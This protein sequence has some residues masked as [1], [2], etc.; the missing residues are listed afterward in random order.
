MLETRSV[1]IIGPPCAGKTTLAKL[2]V[3]RL[4]ENSQPCILLDGDEVRDVF[5]NQLGYDP[6][7]RRK[8]T[9]R[10]KKLARLV[11]SGEILPVIA[12]IHPFEDDRAK[13]REQ[14]PGY[15][16]VVLA[17]DM[18]EL[19]RRDTKKLYLPA[20][21]GKKRHVIGVDIPFDEPKNPNITLHS[22]EMT[23]NDMLE[24]LWEEFID[25]SSS[26]IA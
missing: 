24:A 12:I 9:E 6:K 19:I 1:W 5:E 10:V 14:F 8:Q 22:D 2:F 20:M 21:Q 17:C 4:R 7:S 15:F 11:A 26:R 13:C 25:F 16:E 23:P 3:Q 18:K